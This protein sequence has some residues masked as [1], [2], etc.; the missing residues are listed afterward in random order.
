MIE[1]ALLSVSDKTGLVEFAKGLG[2]LGINIMST[3]GTAKL[4]RE[5]GVEVQ[6]V[7][8]YT[9]FPE[10]MDGRLKTLHPKVHGGILA[11]RNDKGHVKSMK[12]HGI[13]PI[14]LMVVNLY[15]FEKTVQDENVDL[16]VAIENIDIGGPTMI[17]SAAKNHKF[18]AVVVDPNDYN[19]VLHELNDKKEISEDTKQRLALKAFRRTA[20]YDAA[21]DTFLSKRLLDEN[22]L[23]VSYGKGEA[24]RYGE[25]PHQRAFFCRDANPPKCSVAGANILHGKQLSYNNIMDAHAA[26]N[27]IGEFEE[28]ACAILKHTN[29]CGCALGSST[30]DAF[31]KALECDPVSAFGGIIIFNRKLD[32]ETAAEINKLFA[33]IVIAPEYDS[34]ALTELQTKKNLR[35]LETGPISALPGKEFKKVDGGL[36]VQDKDTRKVAEDEYKTVTDRKPT[37]QELIDLKFAWKVVRNIKSNA[38]LYCKDSRTLGV[39]AGQ[40]SRVDSAKVAVM[41][42]HD[43]GLCLDGAVL[44]SDAYFPFPDGVETAAK[45][46]I[47]AIIQPGGSIRDNEVIEAANKYNIA[48]V[49]TGIR[50]FKH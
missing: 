23:R 13:K 25:N 11:L 16:K 9:G 14:D 10:M 47:R 37:E 21:I 35:I 26:I 40:M 28:C 20:D 43:A 39:G 12:E 49:F 8:E 41:K 46:G 18:V 15:P 42:A 27:L 2:R 19:T 34:E 6:D 1:N 48:M 7:S 36:L 38:I 31:Q 32:K 22:I 44:A 4:L 5:H 24:L 29:P 30:T 17:R 50:A 3:G 45:A 33:E